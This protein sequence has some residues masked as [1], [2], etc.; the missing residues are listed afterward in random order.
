MPDELSNLTSTPGAV[1]V[2][3]VGGHIVLTIASKDQSAR[4][5]LKDTAKARDIHTMLAYAIAQVEKTPIGLAAM[6][7]QKSG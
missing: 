7:V 2:D 3:V 5:T 1:L 6:A 4:I